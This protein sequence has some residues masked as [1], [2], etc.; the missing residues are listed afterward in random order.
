MPQENA[1]NGSKEFEGL[2]GIKLKIERA[3]LD[4]SLQMKTGDKVEAPVA[5]I[6]LHVPEAMR[7]ALQGIPGLALDK[8]EWTDMGTD[9]ARIEG[10][11][12]FR[13]KET[14]RHL[15]KAGFDFPDEQK[16]EA[17]NF[18]NRHFNIGTHQGRRLP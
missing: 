2:E 10:L 6:T 12:H 16:R 11:E 8:G 3:Y 17:I 14:F 5:H 1:Y 13:L 7:P 18:L 15:K 9:S 4:I